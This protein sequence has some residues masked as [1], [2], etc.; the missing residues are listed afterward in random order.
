MNLGQRIRL[1]RYINYF[2]S[3]KEK[4]EKEIKITITKDSTDEEVEKYLINELKISKESLENIG[5][6]TDMSEMLFGS[7][8]LSEEDIKSCLDNN[9]IKTEEYEILKMFIKKK[10]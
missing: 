1:H 6:N 8:A 10:R 7:E 5:L 9:L 2:N 3:I 4:K